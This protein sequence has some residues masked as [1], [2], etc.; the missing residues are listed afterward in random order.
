MQNGDFHKK[1]SVLAARRILVTSALLYANGPL[2]LG[3]IVEAT[4][5]DVWVRYQRLSGNEC[6]YVGGD[7]AHGTPIM[8]KAREEGITPE[9]LIKSVG[10][11]HQTDFSGFNID[12]SR[13]SNTHTITNRRLVTSI[14]EKLRKAGHIKHREIEQAYDP[15]AKMFLPDRFIRGTCPKCGAQDQHGDSCEVCGAT[16]RPTDLVRP[17]SAIS[18]VAPE[19]R[20]SEH[21]FFRLADF[22]DL[23][24]DWTH[25][26]A[27]QP[28]VAHKLDE[29]FEAGLQDWDISRDAPYFGFAIP[30]KPDKYFYVWLDAPIGYIA[31]FAELAALQRLNF[32][33][34]WGKESDVELYHFIGKDIAYFHTLFWP[35]ILNGSGYRLPTGVFC[36]G[37]LTINGQKMSKSRGTFIRA[38]TY[39]E[40]LPADYLRYY[41]AAKLSAHVE[42]IDL[43]F[44]DFIARINADLVGKLVNL[45]ARSARFIHRYF[46]GRLA[47]ALPDSA[48]Y[49]DFLGAREIIRNDYENRNF[50][51]V[52]RK[53]MSL[54]DQAN[55]YIDTQKP[56]QAIKSPENKQHVHGVVT[57]SL[58]LFRILMGFLKPITP[59]LATSA[60]TF[61]NSPLPTWQL[62]DEP[63]LDHP[64]QPYEPIATRITAKEIE[65]MVESE[66]RN[67]PNVTESSASANSETISIDDFSR[68]DLRVARIEEASYV[69]GADKLLRLVVDIGDERR[70]VFAGIKAAYEP[71]ALTG[72]HIVVVANLAPRKMRFGV[73]EGMVLAAGSGGQEIFLIHPDEGATAGMKVK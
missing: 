3:H 2:H 30:D 73:S 1:L 19:L 65:R 16:Y 9:S 37:F 4:Q 62:L 52:I 34:W 27:L 40:H 69:D 63:L 38:R 39:L 8:L 46:D 28:E 56:W 17:R 54:A 36:H 51:Q 20:K 66:K 64:I 13:Y 53:I 60:E 33:E 57:E 68:I 43:N 44:D 25:S 35:A 31:A 61:L 18:G 6:Y 41:F 67:K 15:E 14:Y 26:G 72:R 45:A 29:W 10:A 11:S 23:L 71:E 59:H 21:V 49:E 7:D 12:F 58:N 5:T 32:E 48:I 24:H 47:E 50:A 22:R 42:D 55:R 70:Q